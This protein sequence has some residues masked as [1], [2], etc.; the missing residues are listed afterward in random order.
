MRRRFCG[1]TVFAD[2][3]PSSSSSCLRFRG[4]FYDFVS[5]VSH[6]SLRVE[7]L[8]L[9]LLFER[10]SS[11]VDILHVGVELSLVVDIGD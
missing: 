3:F 9:V 5:H 2:V 6:K 7:D 11:V 4:A 10:S 1:S 8:Y